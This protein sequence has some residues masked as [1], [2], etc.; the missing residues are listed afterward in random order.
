MLSFTRVLLQQLKDQTQST[1]YVD[2][3]ILNVQQK[4]EQM[5]NSYSAVELKS[6]LDM[7]SDAIREGQGKDLLAL[8]EVRLETCV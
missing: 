6:Y 7:S 4:A 5:K 1:P 2:K 8:L 3:A